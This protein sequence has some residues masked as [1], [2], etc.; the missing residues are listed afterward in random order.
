MTEASDQVSNATLS[1]T[2]VLRGTIARASPVSREQRSDALRVALEDAATRS[3]A[4][5]LALRLAVEAFTA[6]LRDAGLT[7]EAVL[8]ALKKVV[9]S[10]TEWPGIL[11]RDQMTTWCIEEFFAG[12]KA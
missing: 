2:T 9:R 8:I 6:D 3:V 10:R 12:Q 5:M 1:P 11:I 7:P 4:S